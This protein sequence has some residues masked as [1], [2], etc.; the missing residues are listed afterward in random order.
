M[1][2][3]RPQTPRQTCEYVNGVAGWNYINKEMLAA[4]LNAAVLFPWK[5]TSVLMA[6]R[7]ICGAHS[8]LHGYIYIKA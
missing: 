1:Q 7:F 5:M 8:S 2:T 3:T 6:T 4:M